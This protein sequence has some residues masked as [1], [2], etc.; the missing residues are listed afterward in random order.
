MSTSW[1]YPRNMSK[2]PAF[3]DISILDS[4]HTPG[5]C[6]PSF[7]KR[8]V[9]QGFQPCWSIPAPASTIVLRKWRDELDSGKEPPRRCCEGQNS[10]DAVGR[11]RFMHVSIG[12]DGGALVVVV[13]ALFP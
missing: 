2:K 10:R 7:R 3:L 1:T 9:C 4:Y 6:A 12:I 11:C 8:S 5:L 13:M